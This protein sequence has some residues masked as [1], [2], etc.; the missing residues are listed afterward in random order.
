M[1]EQNHEH[2]RD[3]QVLWAVIDKKE[4][5]VD[6]QQH[7][8]ECQVCNAKVETFRQ[9]LLGFGLKA[10]QAVPPFSRPVKLPA[11]KP[12]GDRHYGGWLPFFGAAAM[13]GLV[14]FFYFMGMKT[15]TPD[16]FPTFQ[17]QEALLEDEA[18]MREISEIV[19]YPL[20]KDIYEITGENGTGYDEDFLDFIVPDMQDDFES[21]LFI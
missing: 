8:L 3:E 7:L 18:L 2:L 5:A 4:L 17:S 19:E 15:I 1:K 6:L 12:S 21:E 20:S 9:D 13:A 14:V 11:A 10:K 16:Q